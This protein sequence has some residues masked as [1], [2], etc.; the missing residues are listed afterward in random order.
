MLNR[1]IS[2]ASETIIPINMILA[3]SFKI[4]KNQTNPI[5]NKVY[6]SLA[7][8]FGL[9]LLNR[10]SITF[11]YNALIPLFIFGLISLS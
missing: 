9:I 2:E 4:P 7:S 1:Q 8:S 6:I 10:E 5:A 3:A 11:W